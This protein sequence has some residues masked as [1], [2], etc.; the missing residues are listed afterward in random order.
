MN[1]AFSLNEAIE[2]GMHLLDLDE[3]EHRAERF[4]Y[5]VDDVDTLVARRG[6][7]SGRAVA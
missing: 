5:L 1:E 7:V 4:E 2:Y 6:F 3:V